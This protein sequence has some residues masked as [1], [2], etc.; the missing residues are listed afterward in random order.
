M[1]SEDDMNDPELRAAIAASLGQMPEEKPVVDLTADSDD[2]VIPVF[3]KSNSLIGSETDSDS[4]DEALKKAIELSKQSLFANETSEDEVKPDA[5]SRPGRLS[6]HDPGLSTDQET[7]KPQG[8]LGIDRKQMEQERLARLAK[9][10]LEGSSEVEQ[11]Q[12]KSMKIERS[13]T[14]E[15]H[16]RSLGVRNSIP[17]LQ[18]VTSKTSNREA[19]PDQIQHHVPSTESTV[20]FPSGAVKKTWSFG[21]RRRGDDIKIEEVFQKSDL[22]VAVLSSFMW[23]MDWLFSKMNISTTQFALIMQAKDN[24]TVSRSL[25]S[26]LSFDCGTRW[27]LSNTASHHLRPYNKLM[28]PCV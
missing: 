7:P 2:D 18:P 25:F 26:R 27:T 11:P 22:K 15:V 13:P 16:G 5:S 10:K 12:A 4:E 9:R 3:P 28:I 14:G 24:A 8:F 19:A 1:S 20:Q 21:C 17:E 6:D 23:E